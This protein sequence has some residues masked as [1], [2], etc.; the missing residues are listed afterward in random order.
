MGGMGRGRMR[1][2]RG[3]GTD[4]VV[5]EQAGAGGGK[6]QGGGRGWTRTVVL[7]RELL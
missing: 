3:K 6:K 4:R 2:G 1:C 5:K 7:E